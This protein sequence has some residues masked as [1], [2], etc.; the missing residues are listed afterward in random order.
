MAWITKQSAEQQIERRAEPF[1]TDAMKERFERE[2]VSRYPWRRSA[3]LPILH[4]IQH[5]YGWIRYQALSEVAEFLGMAFADAFDTASFYEEF[6][7]RPKGRHMVQ[8]CQSMACE[9]CGQPDLL[10]RVSEKLD[11]LPDE[12]TEDG[13]FTLM[14]LECIGACGGA[15]ALLI[16]GELHEDVSWEHLEAKL[17]R[18]ADESE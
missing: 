9:L 8:I 12:T 15:P 17:D 10:R 11:I 16:D 3:I 2:I 18:L 4:E 5:E 6:F 7:F 14:T 1:L 13:K